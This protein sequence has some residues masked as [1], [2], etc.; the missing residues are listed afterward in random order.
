MLKEEINRL[1]TSLID[2]AQCVA[3]QKKLRDE[4]FAVSFRLGEKLV[5]RKDLL[6]KASVLI[7][8]FMKVQPDVKNNLLYHVV[9]KQAEKFLKEVDCE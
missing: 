2:L 5:K 7:E 4:D 3:K 9:C 1:E 6:R 8:G